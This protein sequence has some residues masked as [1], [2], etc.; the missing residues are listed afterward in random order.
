M[1]P[2]QQPSA[3]NGIAQR[4]LAQKP[5]WELER[6]RLGASRRVPVELIVNG[7]VRASTEI[8]ADG[9][10]NDLSWTTPIRES[11]WVA[12]RVW[13]SSHT[14]P[15][16]VSVDNAPVRASRD[17]AKWCLDAVDVCWE[18]KKKQYRDT[19]IDAARAAYEH[20]RATYQSILND[21][22]DR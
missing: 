8:E 19:E 15:I 14:N 12:V 20:A 2:E 16:W 21:T 11:S 10:I 4:P 3:F 5:Y 18:Q 22:M 1:L 7:E 17:S 13:P 9:S 6:A